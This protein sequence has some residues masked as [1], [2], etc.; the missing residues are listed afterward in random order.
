[1]RFMIIRK[2]GAETEAWQMPSTELI[3]AMTQYNQQM[4]DAGIMR[5]GEGLLPSSK[6]ARIKFQ[7][8]KPTITDGPFAEAKELIAGFTIIEVDSRDEALAWV[9]RWPKED[10][11]GNVELE[12]RQIATDEDFG[13][14]FTPELRE[15]EARM[16]EHIETSGMKLGE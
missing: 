14:A 6:G 15:Q 10:A 3:E 13:E 2:A 11:N 9:K 8:G 7:N 4:V 1:M 16:R 5:A 12:L